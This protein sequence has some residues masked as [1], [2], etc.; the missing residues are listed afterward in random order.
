MEL[1]D[2]QKDTERLLTLLE[3]V[4]LLLV[5]ALPRTSPSRKQLSWDDVWRNASYSSVV[6]PSYVIRPKKSQ[7][8][9]LI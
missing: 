7:V 4:R 9:E 2:K 1:E 5:T 8:Y 3:E 6:R